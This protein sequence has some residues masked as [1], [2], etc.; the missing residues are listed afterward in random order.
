MLELGEPRLRSHIGRDAGR[1]E[2]RR[3]LRGEGRFLDDLQPAHGLHMAVGRSPFPHTRIVSADISRALE[4]DGVRHILL[5][6]EVAARS[7]PLTLLRPITEVPPLAYHA[8]AADVALFE[9]QPVVSVAAASRHIAEDALELVEIEFEPVDQCTDV[10][11]AVAPGAPVLHPGLDGNLLAT[12]VRATGD[13]GRALA[14]A[15]VVV[16]DVFSINRVM[17]LPME[18]RGV[19]AEYNPGTGELLVHTSSQTPHLNRK[20]LAE[21]LGLDEGRVRV[22]A[23]MVGGGFGMKLG[24]YP[25]DLLACLH[26]MATGRPVK[27]VEDRLE[28][29]RS[30]TQAREARHTAQ[31]GATADG[32]LQVLRDVIDIDMGAYHSAFGPPS[33]ATATLTGPYLI[34]NC[35]AERRVVA[36]NKPPVGAYRGYGAPESNF[37]CEVLMD[38]MARR[39]GLDPLE[40]RLRNM[41]RPDQLPLETPSGA[42]YDGGNYPRCLELAAERA[43]Y[44][45]MKD[46]HRGPG[47]DGR[48]RGIGLAAYIEKTGYPGSRWLGR[49][50]AAFGAYESVTLRATRSGSVDCYAGIAS[51]GQGGE[52]ALAQVL[53][54]VLGVDLDR[55]HVHVGDTG[56]TP[57]AGGSFSSRTMI[58]ISGAAEQ[59][60]TELSAR[61]RAIAA[62]LLAT[63]P[64]DLAIEGGEVVSLADSAVRM[65]LS[66]VFGAGI[67]GHE[68]PDGLAPGLEATAHFD[69]QAS[70]Y[71]SGA[72]ACVVAVDPRTGE[73]GIERFVLVHDCGTQI[74][75]TLVEGQVLGGL[76]QAL[77]AALMEE[78]IFDPESGQ[79]T[80]GTMM[81]YFAPTAADLPEFELDHIET[82]S[83]V[84]PFGVRGVGEAGTIA[85]NAAIAN[86]ICDALRDFNVVINR[87][88]LTP[89]RVWAA[90]N[91]A[92]EERR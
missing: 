60:A 68:L 33:S 10:T 64:E 54:E 41:I 57:A 71:G 62:H 16:E 15:D 53:A 51:F 88:P 12:T 40:F 21:I 29:F 2:D 74:N 72:A 56:S 6:A 19:I 9:G 25:E 20:Q 17:P 67:S 58:A 86:A 89:E 1:R 77:G 66:R 8:M 47:A 49:E 3:L 59:A 7:A 76:A 31:L 34:E 63:L 70:A 46:A 36:T 14:R 26:S 5:G 55:V 50:G 32:R 24:V 80:N 90:I 87:L 18:A 82:P 13:P 73:F 44:H 11:G 78:L 37:V 84:T 85:P 23:P 35:H 75:P 52:T 4:L 83:P 22:I 42:I 45:T 39:L 43:G 79:L 61:I 48:Y 91:E 81:D 30:S 38:R 92:A 65:P 28:H 69:P 27:W